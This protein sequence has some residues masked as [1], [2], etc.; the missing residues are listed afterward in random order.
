MIAFKGF[1]ED[2]TCTMGSGTFQYEVGKTYQESECKCTAS[3]FHCCENPLDVLHWYSGPKTRFCVAEAG[4]DINQDAYRTKISCTEITSL[5]EITKLELYAYG[6]EYMRKYPKRESAQCVE[7]ESGICGT[8]GGIVV[9]RGKNPKAKAVKGGAFF[10]IRE[11]KNSPD[12]EE[13][14]VGLAGENGIK[15]NVYYG[16]RGKKLCEEKN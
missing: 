16:I 3:G 7:E 12:I 14:Y 10:L 6:C 4:G 8:P 13:I 9:V 2:M 5:K 15:P 1:N 11:K